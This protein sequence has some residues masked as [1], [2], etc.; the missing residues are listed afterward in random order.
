M[1][2]RDDFPRGIRKTLSERAGAM[3]SFPA[4]G[5]ST[6]GPSYEN[7]EKSISNGTA[8]HITAAAQ[9]GRRYDPSLSSEQ[10]KSIDNA[11]WMCPNHGALIDKEDCVYT[12]EEIKGWK[13]D[14]EL[15][16]RIRLE[17]HSPGGVIVFSGKDKRILD[18]YSELFSY[19]SI[20]RIK[21]E[22]F[23]KNVAH[24][25]LRPMEVSL[26]QWNG[27]PAYV[28]QNSRL[29]SIRQGLN[30]KISDFFQHFKQ[31]SAG[32]PECWEYIDLQEVRMNY[33]GEVKRMEQEI[34][35]TQDLAKL[36]CAE[37]MI[38]L[39]LRENHC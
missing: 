30:S 25:T 14:A 5:K 34:Y 19:E 26:Y 21:A 10:R 23:G 22:H 11:I 29:E 1:A 15:A 6:I 16:A 31:H 33:P 36:V 27:N 20:S 24:E 38:L 3:C 17:Q 4:C 39:E 12:V 18:D 35:R 8:A 9:G 32:L 28:F 7:D 2:D 37:A 13:R